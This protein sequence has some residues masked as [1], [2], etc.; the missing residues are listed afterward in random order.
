MAAQLIREEEKIN[1]ISFVNFRPIQLS[2]SLAAILFMGSAVAL[3]QF[4][5]ADEAAV[6]LTQDQAATDV[7]STAPIAYV[8]VQVTNG[9]N[10]YSATA[11]GKLS[12]LK[13]SPFK[14]SGQMEGITGSHLLSV[15]TTILHS[16]EIAPNGAVGEQLSSINTAAYDSGKL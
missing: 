5:G 4:N 11:A 10:V 7:A 2:V 16:Y 13:G 15:G 12:L 3:A 14:V 8:Y 1:M 9:V 6:A